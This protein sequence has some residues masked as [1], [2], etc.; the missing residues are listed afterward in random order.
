M[1]EAGKGKMVAIHHTPFLGRQSSI[2]SAGYVR[3]GARTL[4]SVDNAGRVA[5]LNRRILT[6]KSNPRHRKISGGNPIGD[7]SVS[8][9]NPRLMNAD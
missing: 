1:R 6:H 7:G 4:V 3:G 5:M 9:L 2:P 8:E